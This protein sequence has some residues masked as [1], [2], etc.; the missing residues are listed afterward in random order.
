MTS[1]QIMNLIFLKQYWNYIIVK[2]I[3]TQTQ[4]IQLNNVLIEH[5]WTHQGCDKEKQS[6]S[7]ILIDEPLASKDQLLFII[8]YGFKPSECYLKWN[9]M[10]YICIAIIQPKCMH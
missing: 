2:V 5:S 9:E 8:L 7:Q 1:W 3:S 4:V 6:L 10:F